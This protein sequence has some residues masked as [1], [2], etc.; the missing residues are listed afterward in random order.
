MGSGA[1]SECMFNRFVAA[2]DASFPIRFRQ[3]ESILFEN[4]LE[5]SGQGEFNGQKTWGGHTAEI[6]VDTMPFA[7]LASHLAAVFLPYDT[8]IFMFNELY[9]IAIPVFVPRDLWKWTAGLQTIP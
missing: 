9:A 5:R 1:L 3:L 4:Q 2:N 8:N 6:K 7:K